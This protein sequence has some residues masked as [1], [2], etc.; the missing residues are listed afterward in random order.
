M[1]CWIE[2]MDEFVRR[3]SGSEKYLPLENENEFTEYLFRFISEDLDGIQFFRT[4]R[5][6][7]FST[8]PTE[9]Y[10]FNKRL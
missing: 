9:D 3:V 1:E 4:Q 7:F 2:K 5:L 8:T 6:G 10:P